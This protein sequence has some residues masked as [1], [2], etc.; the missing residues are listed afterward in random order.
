MS[1]LDSLETAFSGVTIVVVAHSRNRL[2]GASVVEGQT[3]AGEAAVNRLG[4]VLQHLEL[5]L[6]GHALR[7]DR[8]A[9]RT[10]HLLQAPQDGR[11]LPAVVAGLL[12]LPLT[13]GALAVH[14]CGDRLAAVPPMAGAALGLVLTALT[15]L[16]SAA[17]YPLAVIGLA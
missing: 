15:A 7:R 6:H 10:P 14:L 1:S 5:A 9:V 11:G 16:G 3:G 17:Y 12:G 8:R 13:A 2:P 4:P